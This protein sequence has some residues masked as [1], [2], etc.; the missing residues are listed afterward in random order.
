VTLAT[1]SRLGPYEVIAAIGAGGMGEVYRA[2]DSRLGRDVAIKI[3]PPQ[4]VAQ[5]DRLRRFEEEARA[6]AGLNHPN[7][8]QIYDVGP[9][10]LV[11]EYIEGTP[12]R[13]P[14]APDEA[15]RLGLQIVSA[16]DA[17]HQR[18]IL[19][20]DLK[21]ANILITRSGGSSDPPTVKLLDFGLAKLM[22]ADGDVTRTIE[23]AVLGT[24]A[25]M[26]PEQA[27][28]RTLDERSDI[29]SLGAV[30]YEMLAGEPAFGGHSTADILSAILRDEPRP[31]KAP[32]LLER[33]VRRCLAK[34][35]ALR[36]QTM[37]EVATAL[38]QAMAKPADQQPSIAVLPFANMSRDPDDEYFSD[39]LAEEIINLLAHVPGLK[40]T[41]RTSAFAFRG[42]EQ[43][44]TKIAEA[45]R[46]RTILEGSVR[47][48]GTRIRVT[49]QLINA[50]D[51]YH[52]WSER[53][54]RELTDV[55]G[56]QDDIAQ[57]IASALQVTL[58]AKTAQARHTPVLAAYEAVLKGRHHMLKHSPGG[59]ARANAC[60]E[61]AM[62]LDPQYS[63]PHASLG[64][65]CFLLGMSGLRSARETMPLVR[66]EAKEALSL[67]P[68]DPGPHF[69][70]ASVAAAYEYDWKQAAEHFAIA[71]AGA[72]VS[73]EAHW[74]YASLYFQPCGRFQ[75]SVAHMEGA[76]ER[77]PLN[78]HWRGVLASH[79][80]HA[81]LHDQA[82]QQANEALEID[83]S[84]LAASV[85]LGEAYI[86]MGRWA[87]AAEALEKAYRLQPQY[88]LSTGML[89]GALVRVGEH[90]R[91]EQM[92]RELGDTPRP[93]IGRVLYH[94][95]CEET[96]QAADWYERA[97]NGR[98]PFALVFADGPLGSAFRAS[99][100]WPKLASM[101]KL[102]E[103]A[104]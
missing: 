95:C 17:A 91:A 67:D 57:A 50:E 14:Y 82:I 35:A 87:E 45:L 39:G 80:T 42:K 103:S 51:G 85:T 9:G 102:P 33:I 47:R 21:P 88:A 81:G 101:M 30:L 77:D 97:I 76:V 20:R 53:Y 23:G 44:I 28:G 98:D 22:G 100:R 8:C 4:F 1:G 96:D 7:I 94:W 70:L 55:F 26:S 43:D 29:F 13:G 6:I 24:A 71:L 75:E 73:A 59:F 68:S 63:E 52:L 5:P 48:A 62:A 32:A 78:A 92:I 90:A 99:S 61:Q 27:Q 60:F 64:L 37:S 3:L 15:V 2:R 65:N 72:S 49:A 41:A 38:Q 79:L 66:A 89:A 84:S 11:L 19:H 46:V 36:F 93:L 54:D 86:A 18:R 12:P 69:L 56:I 25:Y 10:Y 16:L 31:L 74:A 104:I 34:G 40:V 83:E 58:T